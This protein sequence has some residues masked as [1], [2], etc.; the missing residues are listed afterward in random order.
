MTIHITTEMVETAYELL[1]L[2]P[3]FKRWRLPHPDEIAFHVTAIKGRAQADHTHDGTRHIIRINPTR[4]HTLTS[5]VATLAHEMVHM[6]EY[7]MG[8]RADVL[9]GATFQRMAD[10]VC[11]YHS[12]DR[13]QF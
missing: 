11:R 1:R 13:G 8:L 9:H 12:F 3:P 5:M 2:S 7:E 4:H 6:R 10:Q